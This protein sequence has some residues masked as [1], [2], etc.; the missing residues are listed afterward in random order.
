MMYEDLREKAGRLAIRGSE[1][2][3]RD[4]EQEMMS[5]KRRSKGLE[6]EGR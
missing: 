3:D 5:P 4:K 6:D 2:R 1:Q